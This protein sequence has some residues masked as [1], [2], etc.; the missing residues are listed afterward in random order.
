MAKWTLAAAAV[1]TSALAYSAVF[2][3][4][5]ERGESAS[6]ST[7]AGAFRL[8]TTT[9]ITRS[10]DLSTL[11]PSDSTY[12]VTCKVA[13]KTLSFHTPV[14]TVRDG[15]RVTMSDMAR[16]IIIATLAL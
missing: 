2:T 1:V 11:S 12:R 10:S 16:F 5:T 13:C 14:I 7:G 3:S 4:G 6:K 9:R 8:P 15:E